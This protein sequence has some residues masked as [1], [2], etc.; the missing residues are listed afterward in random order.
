MTYLGL[1]LT[2]GHLK[3]VHVKRIIDKVRSKLA[4][5]QGK[6]LNLSGRREL[7]HSVLSAIPVYLLTSLKPPKQLF[8]DIDKAR[9]RFL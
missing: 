3:V 9:Q 8:E 4:G 1:P 7:V 5:W 6:L 2:Q